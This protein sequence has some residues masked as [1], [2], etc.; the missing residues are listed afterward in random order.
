MNHP[1]GNVP[2]HYSTQ[3]RQ[4]NPNYQG[5]PQ[6]RAMNMMGQGPTP[7]AMG[8]RMPLTSHGQYPSHQQ[9]QQHP[10]QLQHQQQQQPGLPRMQMSSMQQQQQQQQAQQQ[11][12]VP[13]SHQMNQ[14]PSAQMHQQM[15][16]AGG[17]TMGSSSMVSQSTYHSAPQQ[18]LPSLQQQQMPPPQKLPSIQP[19]LPIPQAQLSPKKPDIEKVLERALNNRREAEFEMMFAQRQVYCFFFVVLNN[20]F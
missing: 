8:G 1:Y 16:P 20:N 3:Q 14:P 11:M 10:Q 2:P 12:R 7:Q 6:Q 15:P 4:Q 18:Q 5:I 13:P 9:Q 17:S 19:V